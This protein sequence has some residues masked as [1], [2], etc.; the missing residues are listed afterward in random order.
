MEELL[1]SISSITKSQREVE[2]KI[3]SLLQVVIG[4]KDGVKYSETVAAIE[5]LEESEST[6]L[7]QKHLVRDEIL[8][9]RAEALAIGADQRKTLTRKPS[10]MVPR[11]PLLSDSRPSESPVGSVELNTQWEISYD[12]VQ[13]EGK[14]GMGQFGTVYRGKM[15]GQTVAVKKLLVQSFDDPK[16]QED[17]I[18]EVKVMSSLRHP[19]LLL[20]MGACTQ[21]GKMMMVTELAQRGSVYDLLHT[22][23]PEDQLPFRVRMMIA[24]GAALGLNW[25]HQMEPALL[26]L[27]LKT[28]NILVDENFAPKVADFGLSKLK[29]EEH[30][31]SSGSPLYMAPEMLLGKPYGAPADV[32]SFGIVLWELFT[33]SDPYEGKLVSFHSI[34]KAVGNEGKRPDLPENTCQT[35]QVL[36]QSCWS[37]D[38]AQRPSFASMLAD[39]VFDKV[40]IDQTFSARNP[41]AK[42]LWTTSFFG[43]WVVSWE[44]FVRCFVDTLHVPLKKFPKDDPSFECLKALLK[45]ENEQQDKVTIETF[46]EVLEWFGPLDG[47]GILDRIHRQC[48]EKY[49]W[50][51]M[52]ST[53]AEK[54][55]AK[56]K[57]KGSFLVRFSASA[58]GG[59]SLSVLTGGLKIQHFR[60][61]RTPS[62][63]YVLGKTE[64]DSLEHVLSGCSK[65]LRGMDGELNLKKP[66]SVDTPFETLLGKHSSKVLAQGYMPMK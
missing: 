10:V 41:I 60:I 16:A 39:N 25:L 36:L 63:K 13:L 50:G 34:I 59:Y 1:A 7:T 3:D 27:D 35:L 64:Y 42:V 51:W 21:P 28:A 46:S 26:H 20:F 18:R 11:N 14:L 12:S 19:N 5:E 45:I 66:V 58:P 40:I 48:K 47:A 24:K 61:T 38:P 44:N 49:F 15:L 43:Q 8:Y 29:A 53:K 4:L 2:A 22:K 62:G 6:L 56:E 55:L 23:N 65:Q 52:S 30:T 31:G 9:L 17:F 54:V 33:Q 57:Q 32:F 37:S